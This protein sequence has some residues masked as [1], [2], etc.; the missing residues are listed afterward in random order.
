[1]MQH[2]RLKQNSLCL[3]VPTPSLCFCYLI[4]CFKPRALRRGRK[5]NDES[6]GGLLF[7]RYGG[8]SKP[9]F[10]RVVVDSLRKTMYNCTFKETMELTI[11]TDDYKQHKA[12]ISHV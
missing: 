11:A 10:S 12:K 4:V 9:P 7:F 2:T 8:K 1:M 6:T 5:R 3:W